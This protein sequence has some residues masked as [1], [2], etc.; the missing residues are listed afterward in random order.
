MVRKKVLLGSGEIQENHSKTR[1]HQ[2]KEK[3][4]MSLR[5]SPNPRHRDCWRRPFEEEQKLPSG[6]AEDVGRDR[7]IKLVGSPIREK[8]KIRIQLEVAGH[9]HLEETSTRNASGTTW[10]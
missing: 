3:T 10:T 7:E 4:Y 9:P 8:G 5:G 1:H 2:D 6:Q